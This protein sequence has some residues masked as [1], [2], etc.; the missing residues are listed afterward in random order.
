MST[1]ETIM[2]D[3]IK[4]RYISITH[5]CLYTNL[6]KWLHY[7]ST[8][9][10]LRII[11]YLYSASRL[12]MIILQ[13]LIWLICMGGGALQLLNTSLNSTIFIL[14]W[15]VFIFVSNN[16][17]LAKIIVNIQVLYLILLVLFKIIREYYNIILLNKI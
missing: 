4:Y 2:I 3:W 10:F 5:M 7:C 11:Y 13:C 17:F 16:T 9:W 1:L 15:T 14:P 12:T 6:V 8:V